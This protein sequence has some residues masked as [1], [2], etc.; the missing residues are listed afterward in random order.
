MEGF[1]ILLIN[2]RNGSGKTTLMHAL[3]GELN[4]NENS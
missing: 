3:L 1:I 4:Q 2:K